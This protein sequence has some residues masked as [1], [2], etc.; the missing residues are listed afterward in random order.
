MIFINIE[1]DPNNLTMALD[2]QGKLITGLT[3]GWVEHEDFDTFSF[4]PT[5]VEGEIV[6][7]SFA[8]QREDTFNKRYIYNNELYIEPKDDFSVWSAYFL[9]PSASIDSHGDKTFIEWRTSAGVLAIKEYP[10]YVRQ[11]SGDNLTGIKTLTRQLTIHYYKNDG[12]HTEV[13]LPEKKYNDKERVYS[14]IKSLTNVIERTRDLTAAYIQQRNITAGTPEKILPE[15]GGT[16]QLFD[17]LQPEL[18]VYRN[19][20]KKDALIQ[21][22]TNFTPTT[23]VPADTISFILSCVDIELYTQI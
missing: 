4:K 17:L 23:E 10:V 3:T 15:L 20:R 8:V 19:D 18:S 2:E 12:S 16:L 22:L 11:Q 7:A 1:T 13:V 6:L 21:S 9:E 5:L 14:D